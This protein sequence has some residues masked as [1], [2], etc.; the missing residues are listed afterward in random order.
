MKQSSVM[1]LSKMRASGIHT[2][3]RVC[4]QCGC[5]GIIHVDG[6]PGG[7][8]VAELGKGVRCV[9][10]GAAETRTQ[11]NWRECESRNITR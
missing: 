3:E 4:P 6:L 2:V 1:T 5:P 7:V 9:N 11:P 10:C 8:A